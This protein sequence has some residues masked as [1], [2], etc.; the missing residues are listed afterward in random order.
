MGTSTTRLRQNSGKFRELQGMVRIS[1][2][3]SISWWCDN[4]LDAEY[5][6]LFL[7]YEYWKVEH[8]RILSLSTLKH[9]CLLMYVWC[10]MLWNNTSNSN[11]GIFKN[12]LWL[13]SYLMLNW[14]SKVG[15]KIKN[16]VKWLFA[17]FSTK[18]YW[19]TI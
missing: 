8:I 4:Q 16:M 18:K 15:K 7:T 10:L 9:F 6:F 12:H 19:K 1:S 17:I 2:S 11:L 13:W 3:L 5:G 14:K